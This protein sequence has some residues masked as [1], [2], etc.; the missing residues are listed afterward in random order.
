MNDELPSIEEI[1]K[2]CVLCGTSIGEGERVHRS[3]DGEV[4]HKGCYD[5]LN[6]EDAHF[7]EGVPSDSG[8][9]V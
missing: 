5:G 3:A 1:G 4:T 7:Y 2:L 6:D 8:E 9:E